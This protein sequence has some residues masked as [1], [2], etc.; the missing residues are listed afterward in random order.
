[1]IN[2]IN[3]A[4]ILVQ[5]IQ[6]PTGEFQIIKAPKLSYISA[7]HVL[8]WGYSTISD[9]LLAEIVKDIVKENAEAEIKTGIPIREIPKESDN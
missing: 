9:L 2:N 3:N 7:R 8:Q 4:E 1:M 5:I 6:L